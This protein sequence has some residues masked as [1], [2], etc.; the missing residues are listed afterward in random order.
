MIFSSLR[1]PL[2]EEPDGLFEIARSPFTTH[3]ALEVVP[4]KNVYSIAPTPPIDDHP[5]VPANSISGFQVWRMIESYEK[6]ELRFNRFKSTREEERNFLNSFNFNVTRRV[7]SDIDVTNASDLQLPSSKFLIVLECYNCIFHENF[8]EIMRAYP[9]IAVTFR[10]CR[11]LGSRVFTNPVFWHEIQSVRFIN[12]SAPEAESMKRMFYESPQLHDVMFWNNGT[13]SL[14]SIRQMFGVCGAL[15]DISGLYGLDVSSVETA[16]E[17][18]SYCSHI[19]SL[20]GVQSW[21]TGNFKEINEMFHGCNNLTDTT[22]LQKWDMSSLESACATFVRADKLTSLADIALWCPYNLRCTCSMFRDTNVKSAIGLCRWRLP[23]LI[24]ADS[25]FSSTELTSLDGIE[26]LFVGE[27]CSI[28]GMF[29]FCHELR[30][31]SAL[32]KCNVGGIVDGSSLFYRCE[33]VKD[34]NFSFCRNF[35]N[36]VK[37]SSMFYGTGLERTEGLECF[38]EMPQEIDVGGMLHDTNIPQVEA[39]QLLNPSPLSFIPPSEPEYE[40][41]REI[42]GEMQ[43]PNA[44][45]KLYRG[46]YADLSSA[47][48]DDRFLII[49]EFLEKSGNEFF[50]QF[51]Q[52]VAEREKERYQPLN[53]FRT[54]AVGPQ[55]RFKYDYRR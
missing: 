22:A 43:T 42:Y 33:E 8:R 29:S 16:N 46:M 48:N 38:A 23:H 30:D 7:F 50:I 41:L 25:M 49:K 39:L 36:L 24:L 9:I 27:P 26:G 11:F 17:V 2:V 12:C 45:G 19:R 51:V 32:Y 31:V 35:T 54:V 47:V 5:A 13:P 1:E 44:K 15:E 53:L 37:A 20:C 6:G 14:K 55:T 52:R 28:R 34:F 21:N 10:K 40:Q 18:F 4:L 3:D